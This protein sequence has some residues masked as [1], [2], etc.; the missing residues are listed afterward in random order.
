[1]ISNI[2]VDHTVGYECF[3]SNVAMS[4]VLNDVGSGRFYVNLKREADNAVIN[5]SGKRLA[6]VVETSLL[7]EAVMKH[8]CDCFAA[9]FFT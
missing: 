9:L 4:G 2:E 6:F 5:I 8:R 7:T 1:M 3:E